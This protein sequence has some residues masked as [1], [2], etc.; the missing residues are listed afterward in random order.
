MFKQV[1]QP[2]HY[3]WHPSGIGSYTVA[4]YLTFPM[5][6][7][8][9][10]SYRYALKGGVKDLE[11]AINYVDKMISDRYFDNG[12]RAIFVVPNLSVLSDVRDILD[13]MSVPGYYLIAD[14]STVLWDYAQYVF[15]DADSTTETLFLLCRLKEI[16]SREIASLASADATA[17]NGDTL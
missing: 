8:Y 7:V 13:V 12:Y 14:V 3:N 15:D 4:K 1:N 9:K 6:N 2:A 11:K 10:Y 17:E 5:G 16:L